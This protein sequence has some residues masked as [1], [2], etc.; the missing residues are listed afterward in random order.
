[1]SWTR[2]SSQSIMPGTGSRVV[3]GYGAT[4]GVAFVSRGSR[5][6]LPAFGGPRNTIW[7]APCL[8]ILR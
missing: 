8:G 2:T 3:N 7:P 4:S 5:R 6:L 1:M